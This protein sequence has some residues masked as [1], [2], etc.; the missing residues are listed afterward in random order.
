M[1]CNGYALCCSVGLMIRFSWVLQFDAFADLLDPHRLAVRHDQPHFAVLQL[2]DQADHLLLLFR[3]PHAVFFAFFSYFDRELCLSVKKKCGKQTKPCEQNFM[4]GII[5][6]HRPGR[7]G[8]S[9]A[10]AAKPLW[11]ASAMDHAQINQK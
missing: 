7:S 2:P 4:K 11:R 5:F 1:P 8:K 10:P 3:K 6:M 9:P